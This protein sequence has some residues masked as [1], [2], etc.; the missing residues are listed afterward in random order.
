MNNDFIH[1]QNN[2]Y[3]QYIKTSEIISVEYTLDFSGAIEPLHCVTI[4]CSKEIWSHH[5]YHDE[6]K[7]IDAFKKIA[8]KMGAIYE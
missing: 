8:I 7:T 5:Y 1:I 3:E 4:K 2:R 6:Q